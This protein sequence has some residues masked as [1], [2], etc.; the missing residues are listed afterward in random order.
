ME[1]TVEI[2]CFGIHFIAISRCLPEIRYSNVCIHVCRVLNNVPK[3]K[4]EEICNKPFGY[5][6]S[7]F[8]IRLMEHTQRCSMH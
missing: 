2:T 4:V 7:Y 5:M 3:L 6:Y 8:G 1:L